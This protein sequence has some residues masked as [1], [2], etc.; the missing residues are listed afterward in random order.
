MLVLHYYG[1][2][3]LPA[4]FAKCGSHAGAYCAFRICCSIDRRIHWQSFQWDDGWRSLYQNRY[5]AV[6]GCTNLKLSCGNKP[7]ASFHSLLP[8][9][10]AGNIPG[11]YGIINRQRDR[12]SKRYFY[13]CGSLLALVFALFAPIQATEKKR[14]T[15]LQ[16]SALPLTRK[17]KTVAGAEVFGAILGIFSRNFISFYAFASKL[18]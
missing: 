2:H 10:L 11:D 15:Y 8:C 13:S 18:F 4:F 14:I 6:Y 1:L 16:S 17:E 7:A 9:P 12:G 5:A 3:L